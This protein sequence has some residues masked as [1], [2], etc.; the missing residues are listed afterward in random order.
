MGKSARLLVQP[1]PGSSPDDLPFWKSSRSWPWER[2]WSALFTAHFRV[3]SRHSTV[4]LNYGLAFVNS[5]KFLYVKY[6]WTNKGHFWNEKARDFNAK[7]AYCE[8]RQWKLKYFQS[9]SISSFWSL[10]FINICLIFS[11]KKVGKKIETVAWTHCFCRSVFS[12]RI[13]ITKSCN[14]YFA[15]YGCEQITGAKNYDF[16]C[17]HHAL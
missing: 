5:P 3:K 10:P 4:H 1:F 12:Y 14:V 7:F 6:E 9:S 11:W 17:S 13:N 2:G 15:S 8:K 16:P